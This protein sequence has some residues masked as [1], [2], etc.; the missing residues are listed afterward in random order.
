MAD[1]QE[2]DSSGCPVLPSRLL[3]SY[4]T[5]ILSVRHKLV[6]WLH[7]LAE[8]LKCIL[9]GTKGDRREVLGQ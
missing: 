2:K 9:Q 3:D 6:Q 8:H 1:S 4:I 7:M 5:G